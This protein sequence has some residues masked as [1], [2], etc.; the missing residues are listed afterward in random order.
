MNRTSVTVFVKQ[1]YID[2]ANALPDSDEMTV[3]LAELS[4]EATS[5]LIPSFDAVSETESYIQKIKP[6]LFQQQLNAW[7][8]EPRW[9]PKSRSAKDFDAWFDVK[10]SEIVFDIAA[11]EPLLHDDF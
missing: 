6:Y 3:S 4:G 1:P 10:V 7:C 8:T 9:W 5:F 11:E 2:W